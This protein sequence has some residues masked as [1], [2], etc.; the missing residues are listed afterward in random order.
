MT[1]WR[2][3]CPFFTTTYSKWSFLTLN[4][5]KNRDFWDHL[6]PLLVHVV[7]AC[8]LSI[9]YDCILKSLQ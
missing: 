3:F 6:P 9:G 7:I 1:T 5:D 8:L 2:Q 4:V